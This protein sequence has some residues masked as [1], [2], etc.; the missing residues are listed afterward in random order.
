MAAGYLHVTSPP[1]TGPEAARIQEKPTRL[2]CRTADRIGIV[3]RTW[4]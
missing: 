2:G 3:S 1:T 4:A